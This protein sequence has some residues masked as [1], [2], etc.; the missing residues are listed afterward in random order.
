MG[1]IRHC[2][3]SDLVGCLQ[4]TLPGS[5]VPDHDP[6]ADAEVLDGAAIVHLLPSKDVRTN[7]NDY[8]EHVFMPYIRRRLHKVK[9]LDVVWD[10]YIEKSLKQ[11]M[12]ESRGSGE[13]RRVT[14]TTPLPTNWSSFLKV[15]INKEELFNFLAVHI[16]K[17]TPPDGKELVSTFGTGVKCTRVDTSKLEP[18]THEEAD[19]RMMIHVADCVAQ[20][21]TKVTIRTVD[22]DVVVIAVSV[23]NPLH[24]QELWIAFGTGKTFRYI[25]A[26]TISSNLG[27]QKSSALP[28]FHSLTGCDTVSSFS[29][30]G[31][32]TCWDVWNTF[33]RLTL[34]QVV[35]TPVLHVGSDDLQNIQRFTVLL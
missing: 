35:K 32:K 25:G 20:G 7:F 9:R 23:V 33:E 27:P 24:L 29:G 21:Y 11:G 4:K 30:R 13:R 16:G 1:H 14:K 34:L 22:T 15:D 28:L 18:C 17:E 19:T 8:E 10:R 31:K 3:K 5:M 2:T 26:H 6:V 12:R